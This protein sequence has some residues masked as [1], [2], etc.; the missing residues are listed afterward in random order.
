M[1][2]KYIA[3]EFNEKNIAIVGSSSNLLGKCYGKKIDAADTVIRINF[4]INHIENIVDYGSK[5]DVRFVGATLEY[6]NH[7]HLIEL[8]KKPTYLSRIY[9]RQVNM[10]YLKDFKNIE[11]ISDSFHELVYRKFI[12]LHNEVNIQDIYIPRSGC[13]FLIFIYLY[14]KAKSISVY[15]FSMSKKDNYKYYDTSRQLSISDYDKSWINKC[16]GNIDEEIK[17]L[18]YLKSKRRISIYV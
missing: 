7:E 16:H 15:G 12:N 18:R 5:C 11:F 3:R 17:I 1:R 10:P 6:K 4:N 13:A 9:T 8:L 14:S 2:L